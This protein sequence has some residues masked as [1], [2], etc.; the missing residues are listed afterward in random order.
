M[1]REVVFYKL[2][3]KCPTQDFLDSLS[4][5]VAQKVLWTLTL[6]EDLEVIP[7]HYFCKMTGTDGIWE[8]RIKLASNIYRLL[9]FWDENKIILSHGF[10]KKTQKTPTQQIELAEKYKNDYFAKKGTTK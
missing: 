5:K 2:N 4:P 1:N 3:N 6:L 8:C 7:A 9:A 10:I